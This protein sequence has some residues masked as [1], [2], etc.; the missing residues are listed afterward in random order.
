[1]FM[2][3]NV[4]PCLLI[5]IPLL[6]MILIWI[7][8]ITC[9]VF[10]FLFISSSTL[11]CLFADLHVLGTPA[12]YFW[13][14]L[15]SCKYPLSS[16]IFL[17]LSNSHSLLFPL[18]YHSRIPFCSFVLSTFFVLFLF[19]VLS[20]SISSSSLTLS[21]TLSLS[22]LF[23]LFLFACFFGYYIYVHLSHLFASS[24]LFLIMCLFFLTSSSPPPFLSFPRRLGGKKRECFYMSLSHILINQSFPKYIRISTYYKQ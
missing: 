9:F 6:V 15:F 5:C 18:F 17:S 16:P 7:F 13:L 3:F 10:A 11:T 14:S 1:M 4:F 23:L 8:L 21:H 2:Y 19:C 24:Y 22:F 20:P 12:G